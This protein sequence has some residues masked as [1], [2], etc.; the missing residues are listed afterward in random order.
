MI[1]VKMTNLRQTPSSVDARFLC[2]SYP[3]PLSQTQFEFGPCLGERNERKQTNKQ[4]EYSPSSSDAQAARCFTQQ[5]RVCT[6]HPNQKLFLSC[7]RIA[8]LRPGFQSADSFNYLHADMGTPVS[9]PAF[10]V[11]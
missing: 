3:V 2:A 4:A 9:M 5:A 11:P 6:P 1:E 8:S 7:I 10:F